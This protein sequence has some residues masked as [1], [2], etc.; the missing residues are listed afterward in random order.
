MGGF[1]HSFILIQNQALKHFP[2]LL[3]RIPSDHLGGKHTGIIFTRVLNF[4]K[5]ML[6]HPELHGLLTVYRSALT[7]KGEQVLVEEDN[8]NS[9]TLQFY[10]FQKL[11]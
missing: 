9:T 11:P 6:I 5:G 8:L 1:Y 2:T 7:G 3:V 4:H 10:A